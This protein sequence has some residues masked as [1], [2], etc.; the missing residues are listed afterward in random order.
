[1]K[2]SRL[3]AWA[4]A[5]GCVVSLALGLALAG[6]G[7]VP[8]AGEP[9]ASGTATFGPGVTPAQVA[10]SMPT[11]SKVMPAPT[12]AY[13]GV[14]LAAAPFDP[15]AVA[16]FTGKAGKPP[17]IV[18][19]YQPW[20]AGN[21]DLFDAG[22]CVALWRAGEVPMI[23]WEPWDPGDNASMLSDPQDQP[24]Y[25]LSDIIDGR[26]DRYIRSWA[27]QI[28][29]LGGPVMLR[30]MHEMNGDWYPW[31]GEANG[32][33]PAQYVAAWRH[34]HDIF[35]EEGATN[36]TWVW[37]INH[38]SVPP[39]KANSFAAYYPGSAYVDWTAV[40]GYNWGSAGL[41]TV[42]RS[43]SFWYRAPLAFLDTLGKP[44][45]IAEIGCVEQGGNKAAWLLDAYER[46][47]AD[48]RIKAVIYSDSVDHGVSSTQDWRI[49]TS[50]ASLA[51]FRRA[52]APDVFLSGA[53]AALSGWSDSLS[54]PQNAFLDT[55]RRVY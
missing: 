1:M 55:M 15:D 54:A 24:K 37:S 43:F 19:W 6:C 44:I 30:P 48:P 34:I 39:T 21:R 52:I 33:T 11:A 20:V 2:T 35:T 3:R 36:V 27:R 17:A 16:S 13:L 38:E 23:T 40:S 29:D 8:T 53:P 18:M 7:Q 49:D 42:W 22:A 32:N 4:G 12:G 25:R 47:G 28:R 10:T 45:C 50:A 9:G 31:C 41:G 5:V 51:A 26:F 14:Y 46:I